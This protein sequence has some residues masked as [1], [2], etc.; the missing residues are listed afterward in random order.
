MLWWSLLGVVAY[1]CIVGT[2]LPCGVQRGP[3]PRASAN[4]H[5][6]GRLSPSCGDPIPFSAIANFKS[7]A[8]GISENLTLVA[9]TLVHLLW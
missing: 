4:D 5:L 3:L 7:K 9:S 6:G 1:G 8:E 2:L